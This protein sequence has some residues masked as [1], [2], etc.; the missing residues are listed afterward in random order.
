MSHNDER[1]ESEVITVRTV[2]VG[3]ITATEGDGGV[4]TAK[5]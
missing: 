4:I 1:G 2:D 3:V 5:R